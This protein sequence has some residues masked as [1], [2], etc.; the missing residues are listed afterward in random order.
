M[1]REVSCH[2]VPR[3]AT[4]AQWNA[5]LWAFDKPEFAGSV[6]W[7][8]AVSFG[9]RDELMRAGT[10][11]DNHQHPWAIGGIVLASTLVCLSC[12]DGGFSIDGI[13]NIDGSWVYSETNTNGSDGE[14]C[15]K[16]GTLSVIQEQETF[17]GAFARTS[18]CSNGANDEPTLASESGSI[19]DGQVV[20]ES[21]RFRLGG[22]QYRGTVTDEVPDGFTGT[23]LCST[24]SGAELQTA[25]GTWQAERLT[26]PEST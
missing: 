20:E 19:L 22:C 4:A 17:V 8:G 9:L 3:M 7:R 24:G 15:T 13:P 2:G 16:F 5:E 26:E 18:S 23:L 14:V 1:G 12:S 11:A 21:I 10:S 6:Q 25:V